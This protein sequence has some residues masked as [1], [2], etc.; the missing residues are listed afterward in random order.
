MPPGRCPLHRRCYAAVTA[1]CQSPTRGLG[2]TV[3]SALPGGTFSFGSDR[4]YSEEGPP[5]RA[6][7]SAFWVDVHPV[8]N[9]QFARFVQAT[10]YVTQAEQGIDAQAAP[11]L[12]DPLRVPGAMVFKQ[13]AQVLRPGWQFVA[14]ANWRHPLG[15]GS[16]WHDRANHPVVQVTLRDAQAYA[17]W[18]GRT[19]PSE[20]QLEYAMRGG[21]QDADFSWGTAERPNGNPMANTW[22]GQF[23][24]HNQALDGFT[25]TSPVGCFVANG[26][27]LFDAGGN[28]WELT[29]SGYRPGHDEARDAALDPTGP[30]LGDSY[31]PVQPGTPVVVI[32]GVHTCA[33]RMPACATGLRHGSRRRCTWQRL[34]WGFGRCGQL[35]PTEAAQ[36]ACRLCQPL[37]RTADLVHIE[38]G[39]AQAQ[40]I[41]AVAER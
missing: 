15:P 10:G 31:D 32:K 22:Q 25:G 34:M 40:G 7:V 17:R 18:A 39:E 11:D 33:R 8:T 30:A 3:W 1:A 12:P 4:F 24:Y 16:H 5:H 23:P 14:G 19:L 6:K 9:A 36:L 38:R 27:G 20:A 21:L 41:F 26:F 29:R 35:R 13:G 28:V 37:G 2:E